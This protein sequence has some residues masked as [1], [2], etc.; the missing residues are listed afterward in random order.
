[1]TSLLAVIPLF[2][3]AAEIDLAG[4]W[5]LSGTNAKGNAIECP[6][7]VPGDVHSALL[8]ARLI[9]D[10]FW[11][12]NET[13]VLWASRRDWTIYREFNVCPDILSA[14]SVVLRLDNV[15]TFATI[16][17]NGEMVGETCNRFRRWEFDVKRLLHP[18]RNTISGEFKC[19]WDVADAQPYQ[20]ERY[21]P[22]WTNGI[23]YSINYIRKPQCHGGWDWGVTQMTTGFCGEIRL[24]AT[25]DFRINYIY[26]DQSFN[27]DLSHC[28]LT[29]FAEITEADGTKAVVTNRFAIE[30]PRLWWPNGMG[31]QNFHE[32]VLDVNGKKIPKRIGLRS[33]EMVNEPDRDPTTG[34]DGLSCYFRVNGRPVF[35]KG[36]NWI[37]CDAFE[38]RQTPEKYR[39]L[40]LSA[41]AANMNMIRLWGGGQY[42]KDVFYD[43]C[44]ELGLMVW[45][46]FMFSCANYPDGPFLDNVRK[47]VTH[48]IKRLRDHA[49]I[50][51]WCGDN[52]CR[53]CFR[54]PWRYVKEN[55]QWY[56][57]LYCR[58]HELLGNLVAL[59]DPARKF[60]PTSPC[61]GPADKGWDD[62]DEFK[63][64][65]HFWEVW[66]G[67]REF[68]RFTEIRPRF[69][70]EFGFQSFPSRETCLTFC[71]P[72]DL[73]P[74]SPVFVHHQKNKIGNERILDTM[75]RYFR[76]PR[77]FGAT[78]YLSQVQQA[79]AIKTAIEAWR[80]QMPW[81][82]GTLYWQLNDNWPV[83]SWS[84]LE[85]GGKWKQLHYHAKRFY[86][87]VAIAA[88]QS[89]DG[90]S[91]EIWVMNDTGYEVSARAEGR[92]MTFG[93]ET[94]DLKGFDVTLAPGSAMRIATHRMDEFGRADERNGRF[95]AL[96]I[97]TGG[98]H[99]TI[100]RNE[101]FFSP[102]RDCSI[103]PANVKVS[104]GGS[105]PTQPKSPC[106][107][108]LTTDKPAF[109]VWLNVTGIRGEFSD[110]SFTLLPDEPRTLTF[111]PKTDG[112]SP[113]DFHAALT[114][115][116]LASAT[117]AED[118]PRWAR[119]SVPGDDAALKAL[120]LQLKNDK[121]QE[122]AK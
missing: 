112:V 110:N 93:G 117:C 118:G 92:L 10:P 120:G 51:L 17:V 89:V 25:D 59:L 23:V 27:E 45:H 109:F 35:A 47:E 84:S 52:E 114:V 41:K 113:H 94:V 46:D 1:M 101:W 115:T 69:C 122:K 70:S 61:N 119:T 108:T 81:C 20:W 44:D 102:Y 60:W 5:R 66:H 13:N 111:T 68:A 33:V 73:H 43:L 56:Y 28:D 85:Y 18:G 30:K 116:H 53:G 49:S 76:R 71:R 63:G 67:N 32:V 80:S 36:A 90:E 16:R 31:A 95:L 55:T 11:G 105:V 22:A 39:D 3:A 48:Q 98:I 37:P 77:D 38:N 12:C 50:A 83:A 97:R 72:D 99:P 82:M 8:D 78:L 4:T 106:Q 9:D 75:K 62:I 103:A 6:V 107:I 34:R 57:A 19:A 74:Y 40:L 91:V 65:L 15:D 87:P 26:S 21:I 7:V 24:V 29:V 14:S 96:E 58:R 121:K 2:F 86:A 42:E 54:D 104:F 100:H 79:L 88:K 64:D